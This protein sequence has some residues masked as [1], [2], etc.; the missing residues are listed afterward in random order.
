MATVDP[1]AAPP[2]AFAGAP[3]PIRSQATALVGGAFDLVLLDRLWTDY[4]N[5]RPPG[6]DLPEEDVIELQRIGARMLGLLGDVGGVSGGLV[7]EILGLRDEIDE[8]FEEAFDEHSLSVECLA[9]VRDH[10]LQLGG[11]A[12]LSQEAFQVLPG[13]AATEARLLAEKL[14]QIVIERAVPPS[15]LS[16]RFLRYLCFAGAGASL[17]LF[18]G[19]DGAAIAVSLVSLGLQFVDRAAPKP[20]G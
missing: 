8:A 18:A 17:L 14:E 2:R 4:L 3:L 15:D 16:P 20:E 11:M 1:P 6:E 19:A 9:S 5:G 7:P 12:S 13:A 10:A